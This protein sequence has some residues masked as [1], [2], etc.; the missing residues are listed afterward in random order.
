MMIGERNFSPR[1]FLPLVGFKTYE[2]LNRIISQIKI[3]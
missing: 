3:S 1:S 2:E